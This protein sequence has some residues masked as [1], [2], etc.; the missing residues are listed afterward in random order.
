M[1]VV[2]VKS[3]LKQKEEQI[4]LKLNMIISSNPNPFPFERINKAKKLIEMIHECQE[5]IESDNLLLAGMK[6]RDLELEGLVF[7]GG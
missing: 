3:E 7:K 2:K 5:Y 4:N 1:E 6:L